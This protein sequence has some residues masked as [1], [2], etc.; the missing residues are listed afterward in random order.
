MT[1]A[2]KQH[3]GQSC[4]SQVFA[5]ELRRT[6]HPVT[7][8]GSYS[9]RSC[10][11]Q[12]TNSANAGCLSGTWKVPRLECRVLRLPPLDQA[13]HGL[14]TS[15]SSMCVSVSTRA[16]MSK[17]HHY[18]VS[19]QIWR[20]SRQKSNHNN[21]PSRPSEALFPSASATLHLLHREYR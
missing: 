4:I 7:G 21:V 16:L 8:S 2:T 9:R 15:T 19:Q 6:G 20:G 10:H 13:G 12:G 3:S 11:A 14:S 17:V 5:C 1:K 18:C